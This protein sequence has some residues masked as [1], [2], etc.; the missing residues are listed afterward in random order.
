VA[1][2]L[3]RRVHEMHDTT[4]RMYRSDF[5]DIILEDAKSNLQYMELK[6]KLHQG[7]L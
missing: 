6:E 4:I 3:N 2:A 1:Y 7:I 5:K